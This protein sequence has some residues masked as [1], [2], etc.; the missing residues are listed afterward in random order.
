MRLICA[1]LVAVTLVSANVVAGNA[2]AG[3]MKAGTC[4]G[5]HGAN[6]ISAVPN[7]P[8][9][10]GQKEQYLIKALR[11]YRDGRRTDPVMSSTAR[12]LNDRDIDNMAAYFSRL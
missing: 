1:F 8:N 10:K 11:A 7:Y 9:L 5:C 4:A 2:D 12:P 3:K 6:G